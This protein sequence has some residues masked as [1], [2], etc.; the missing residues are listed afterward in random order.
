[1]TSQIKKYSDLEATHEQ[2]MKELNDKINELNK[3]IKDLSLENEVLVK[4]NGFLTA[5]WKFKKEQ[6]EAADKFEF[7]NI[8]ATSTP[9]TGDISP[10]ITEV[11]EEFNN[12]YL[13][14][15]KGEI[16]SED[17]RAAKEL[18]KRNSRYP[19]HMRDSYAIQKLDVN[20]NEDE[21]K[22]GGD[23]TPLLSKASQKK[24]DGTNYR[25][26][27]MLP[28][29]SKHGRP[30]IGGSNTLRD[31]TNTQIPVPKTPSMIKQIFGRMSMGKDEVSQKFK[32]Y[33]VLHDFVTFLCM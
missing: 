17:I 24:K 8:A 30:S 4:E 19:P 7:A 3:I 6:Q 12:E 33:F 1:M 27:S 22:H 31:A 10:P 14:E 9:F 13:S 5:Q 15:L 18:Q 32:V 11:D 21:I 2:S 26:P 29:P 28:T 23:K 16:E 20:M 25:R